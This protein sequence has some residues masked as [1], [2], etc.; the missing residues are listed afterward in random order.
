VPG[1]E[2]IHQRLSLAKVL[3]EENQITKN[4]NE[5]P[6]GKPQGISEG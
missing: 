2:I 3:P 4:I 1:V 5:L 6:R